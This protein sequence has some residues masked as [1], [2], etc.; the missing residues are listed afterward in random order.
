MSKKIKSVAEL[1]ALRETSKTALALRVTPDAAKS[2]SN[3]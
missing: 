1:R 2:A 3:N